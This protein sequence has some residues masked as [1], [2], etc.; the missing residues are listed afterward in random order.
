MQRL[1]NLILL[2]PI[3]LL[4]QSNYAPIAGAQS[5]GLG[6]STVALAQAFSTH[7]NQA[8]LTFLEEK[9]FA[10]ASYQ[11]RYFLNNL[12][13]G[14]FGISSPLANGRIALAVSYFGFNDYNE[15]KIG[16]AYARKFGKY[17]AFSL[18][19][20][21]EQNYVAE[22]QNLQTLT[23]EAGVLAQLNEKLRLGFHLYNPN[24]AYLSKD[25]NLRLP[26]LARLGMAFNFSEKTVFLVEAQN[27]FNSST[28]YSTGLQ[29]QLLK[30][31]AFRAG[32]AVAD[33]YEA[34]AGLGFF[35]KDFSAHLAYQQGFIL[36]GNLSF[37]LQCQF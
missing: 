35:F 30:A 21:Y 23:F 16:L 17:L 12:N 29:Y 8:A 33:D 25:L 10:A 37:E 15:S 22:T 13:L 11:Q 20:N 36:G 5:A 4:A 28:R 31:L 9:T 3:H 19:F 14:H 32:M 6:H 27:E 18:Q 7:H 34:S 26:S 24:G 2:L 1:L